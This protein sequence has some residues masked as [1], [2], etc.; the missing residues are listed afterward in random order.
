[1]TSALN[2]TLFLFAIK[3]TNQN[4]TI[5]QSAETTEYTDCVSA[6]G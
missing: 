6:E 3:E 1:M 4:L 2:N 5:A